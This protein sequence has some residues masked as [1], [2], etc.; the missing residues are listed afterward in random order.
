MVALYDVNRSS[1]GRKTAQQAQPR[2]AV[3]VPCYNEATTIA[4]VVTDFR[5]ALPQATIY[6]YDNNSKDGTAEIA[7]EAGAVVR[8]E[9]RQ[10]KGQVVR[11]MFADIDADVYVLVDGDDT[12]AAPAAAQAIDSVLAEGVDFVNIARVSTAVEAYRPGHRLGNVMLTEM[13]RMFFGRQTSDMLSGY[14]VLSRRFVKSFPAMSS[15]FETE[16]ELTVHALEMRM[17]MAEISAP[18]KERPPGSVSKLNTF[19]DGWRI[20]MLI[21]RLIKDERPLKFFSTIGLVLV[22]LAIGISIPVVI[23]WLETGLVPRLPTAVLSVGMVITGF[24]SI[25]TGLILD[26]VTK[27]RQEMKRMAYL[28][29]SPKG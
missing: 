28:A 5:L 23:T 13:V 2:V 22:A 1:G 9:T 20:L 14:K 29:I 12:Y 7:R 27:S 25:F 11:R 26:V 19:R 17:P 21:A 6:V 15:G 10:G 8:S 3:L 16:T 18:Y 24:L 4:S